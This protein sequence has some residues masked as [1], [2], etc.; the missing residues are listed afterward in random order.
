M[1]H[2]MQSGSV[3]LL[4]DFDVQKC[5]YRHRWDLPIVKLHTSLTLVIQSLELRSLRSSNMLPLLPI[6]L[7]CHDSFKRTGMAYAC[8]CTPSSP[9]FGTAMNPDDRDDQ[10]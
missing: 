4:D 9:L 6:D 2:F 1:H 8:T 3:F 10:R 5:R 7:L